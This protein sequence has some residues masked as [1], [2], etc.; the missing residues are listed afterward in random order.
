MDDLERDLRGIYEWFYTL[1]SVLGDFEGTESLA[2]LV[3]TVL[4]NSV[5]SGIAVR[6]RGIE[7]C[8]DKKV[9]EVLRLL[10]EL[11]AEYQPKFRELMNE[12]TG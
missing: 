4:T 11:D 10:H 1:S 7:N 2:R 12:Q 9:H 3:R 6:H 8:P 5:P